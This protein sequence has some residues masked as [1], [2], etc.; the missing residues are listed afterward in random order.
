MLPF[1][2]IIEVDLN[3]QVHWQHASWNRKIEVDERRRFNEEGYMRLKT[4]L[5]IP[6]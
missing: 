4:I 3:P 5:P 6:F 2:R 1:L